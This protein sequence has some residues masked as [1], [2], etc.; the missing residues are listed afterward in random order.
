M[1]VPDFN[2]KTKP[3]IFYGMKGM[4]PRSFGIQK[5]WQHTLESNLILEDKENLRIWGAKLG[6]Q[7]AEDW[8]NVTFE[9]I[10]RNGGSEILQRSFGN[11][12]SRAVQTL[13]PEEK[14]MGWKFKAIQKQNWETDHKTFF[15]WLGNKLGFQQSEDWYRLKMEDITQN[16]GSQVISQYGGSIYKALS[17]IY[18]Q[19]EW[20]PWKFNN[21]ETKDQQKEYLEWLAKQLGVKQMEDWY[22]V[23]ENR[24]SELGG[25]SLLQK[26]GGKV[27]LLSQV[28]SEHTWRMEGN[29]KTVKAKVFD[30]S[31]K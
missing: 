22:A 24:I 25:S 31:K 12:L 30:F 26:F 4:K 19:Y 13:H 7:K 1:V 16:E 11:S 2:L 3:S 23:A 21:L 9:D 8:Y 18:P 5:R 14:W 10:H 6:I 28:Y 15:D 20:L 17:S 29:W 27:H